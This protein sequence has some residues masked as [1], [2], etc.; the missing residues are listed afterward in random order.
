MNKPISTFEREMQDENFRKM[1]EEEYQSLLFS[2]LMISL[3]EED[4]NKL[5]N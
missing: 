2:E 3:I 5:E 1:F 4:D